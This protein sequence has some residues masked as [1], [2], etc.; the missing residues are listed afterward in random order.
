MIH[1]TCNDAFLLELRWI[2]TGRPFP[3]IANVRCVMR[4]K[5]HKCGRVISF[6]PWLL[7]PWDRKPLAPT[8][9]EKQEGLIKQSRGSREETLLFL[10]WIKPRYPSCPPSRISHCTRYTNMVPLYHDHYNIYLFHISHLLAYLLNL[11]E[12]CVLYIGPAYR[13]PPAVAFYTFFSTNISTEYFKHAAHS[14]FFSLKFR[15]FHNATFFGSCTIHILH[16]E[17]AKI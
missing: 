2:T 6:M 3:D 14:L 7:Y 16:T 15:L 5:P 11:W 10:I 17:C 13:Y 12:P 9:C 4:H 1:P 8:K